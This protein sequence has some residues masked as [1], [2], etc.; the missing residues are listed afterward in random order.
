LRN[1]F[2]GA[3]WTVVRVTGSRLEAVDPDVLAAVDGVVLDTSVGGRTGGTGVAFDWAAAADAV[4]SLADRTTVVLA[5]GLHP[6][7]VAD[8][9]R[10]LAP[11]VVDVSSGV[12]SSPG[13]KDHAMMRA[14]AESARLRED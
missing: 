8:A 11:R 5:G 6:G 2:A 9:V 10:L 1:G 4:R 7:N 14:F 12:E 13:V 3:I